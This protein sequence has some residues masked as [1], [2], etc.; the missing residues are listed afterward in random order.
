MDHIWDRYASGI[1]RL[2]RALSIPPDFL[3]ERLQHVCH[4]FGTRTD[5]QGFAAWFHYLCQSVQRNGWHKYG[6]F[7][8]QDHHGDV[9]LVCFGASPAVKER[10]QAFLDAKAWA[11]VRTEPL[12]LFDLVLGG[13]FV[14]FDAIVWNLLDI[15]GGLESVSWLTLYQSIL[16]QL[17]TPQGQHLRIGADTQVSDP[18]TEDIH[19]SNLHI[20]AKNLIHLSETVE[21]CRLV[22]N[23]ALS[24]LD[25]RAVDKSTA[26]VSTQLKECLRYRG[27]LFDSTKLRISSLSKRVDNTITLAF[28][29]V[30]QQDSHL[31][32]RDSTSMAIVSFVTVI[33]LP[34]AGVASVV[35]SQLFVTERNA[36]DGAMTTTSTPL[37][38]VLWFIAIPLTVLT[39]AITFYYRHRSGAPRRPTSSP[40]VLS[41]IFNPFPN[42]PHR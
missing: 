7:L 11:D 28:N 33:F 18:G 19:F 30:T 3:H 2:C 15:I 40:E 42:Q 41:T 34:T 35:G 37:F 8:R 4:S 21:S 6:F 16:T 36:V 27:S 39:T 17:L 22:V 9:T 12:A 32:I 20:W 26:Q 1:V 5:E 38:P 13:L 31:M 29:L 25:T 24:Y 10:L 23:G 14:E